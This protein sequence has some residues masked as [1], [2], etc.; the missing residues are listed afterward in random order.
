MQTI[1][2]TVGALMV[3][4]L[5]MAVGVIFTGRALK[6]SCGGVGGSCPCDEAGKPGACTDGKGPPKTSI[7]TAGQDGVLLHEPVS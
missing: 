7:T 5:A 2:V 3:I 6:G 4:M 1:L